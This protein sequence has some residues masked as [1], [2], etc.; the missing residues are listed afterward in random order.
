MS[1]RYDD[2]T[3]DGYLRTVAMTHALGRAFWAPVA[4]R[5][6]G[7]LRGQ[8]I[9]PIL[10]R[11]VLAAG[12]GP[13]GLEAGVRGEAA[14]AL[15]WSSQSEA[16]ERILLCVWVTLFAPRGRVYG[17]PPAGA[18]EPLTV[19]RVYAE[20]V[21]T[22]PFAPP[23]EHRVLALEA[24]GLPRVPERR[25][26]LVTPEEVLALPDG[27]VWTSSWQLDPAPVVFGIDHTDANQHVNSL[28][29]PQLF[30]DAALRAWARDA[31]AV[32]L[33]VVADEL[34]F[35]KPCF[36]GGALRVAVR[37]YVRGERLGAVAALTS[38]DEAGPPAGKSVHVVSRLEASR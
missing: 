29:Y 15:A 9:V 4:P 2:V 20:H 14:H 38:S 16:V 7:G 24:P 36:A 27:A 28:V 37:S 8:G 26:P 34:V 19:G 32:G 30:R 17:P 35:R 12:E 21:F 23:G 33:R 11:M 25:V 3:Q 6:F 5:R 18:G 10:S 1:L 31:S 22:R 13:I